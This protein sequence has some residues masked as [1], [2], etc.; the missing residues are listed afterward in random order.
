MHLLLYA[1]LLSCCLADMQLQAVATAQLF[2][3][4]DAAGILFVLPARLLTSV[5]SAR[6]TPALIYVYADTCFCL[7]EFS[8]P[9]VMLRASHLVLR[10]GRHT[11]AL[12]IPA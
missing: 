11:A 6:L 3:A 7:C 10:E 9:Q 5:S 2:A 8:L 12:L 4:G 1:V